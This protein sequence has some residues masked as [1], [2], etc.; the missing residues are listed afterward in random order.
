L[1]SYLRFNHKSRAHVASAS[2]SLAFTTK[3]FTLTLLPSFLFRRVAISFVEGRR[4]LSAAHY[5][6][7]AIQRAPPLRRVSL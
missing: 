5:A 2:Y 7:A 3:H 6:H 1:P 4:R